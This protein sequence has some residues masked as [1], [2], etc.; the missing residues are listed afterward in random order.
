MNFPLYNMLGIVWPDGR[1]LVPRQGF[2][3]MELTW[4]PFM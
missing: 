1:L 2:C 4:W 3:C